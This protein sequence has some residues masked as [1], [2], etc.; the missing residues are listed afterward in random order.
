MMLRGIDA[1]ADGNRLWL[2]HVFAAGDDLAVWVVEHAIHQLDLLTD[3]PPPAAALQAARRTVESLLG[4]PPPVEW[5]DADVAFIG[6][7]RFAVPAGAERFADRLPVI[8]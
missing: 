6:S 5:S 2:G 3:A 1:V 7:S 8:R 4:E